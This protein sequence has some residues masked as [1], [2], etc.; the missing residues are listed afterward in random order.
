MKIA[1][2]GTGLYSLA[3][4]SAIAKNKDNKITMW[5]EDESKIKELKETKALKSISEACVIPQNIKLSNSYQETLEHANLIFII[6]SA[7]YM[8]S[9]CMEIK[10]YISPNTPICIG[11]KGIEQDTCRFVTDVFLNII[12][13]KNIS[14]ISGPSFA[15]DIFNNEPVALTI[16]SE[17][18]K[19]ISIVKQVLQ[20]D[21]LKLR[22]SNDII[23]VQICGSIKNVIALASGILSGLGY[24]ESTR[25][26]LITESSHD[27]KELIR[28]LG[29]DKRTIMSFAG[30]GDLLLTCTS[31]KSRNFS[32]GKLIGERKSKKEIDEHLKNNT[33]EGYYTLKS[34]HKLVKTKKIEMPIIDLIYNIVIK[35]EDPSLLVEFLI[36]KK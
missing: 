26:F 17:S 12:K 29:G 7:K 31:T 34:I 21:K 8:E 27:I 28:C 2:I 6:V 11:T 20:N 25:A 18:K 32:F 30:V 23:G 1:I 16:A 35:N 19:T 22:P 15:I 24:S 33:V 4:A 14:V 13:T 36:N 10:S 3:I 5:T 9:V